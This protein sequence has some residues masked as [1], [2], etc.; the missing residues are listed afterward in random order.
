[1]AAIIGI[2]VAVALIAGTPVA[3][4]QP[5]NDECVDAET[6][7]LGVTAFGS[8]VDATGTDITS[9][10]TDDWNDVWYVCTAGADGAL[11]VDLSGSDFDTTLAVYDACGGNELACN[12]DYYGVQSWVTFSAVSGSSYYIRAAGYEGAAG[13]CHVL[14]DTMPHPAN[15]ECANAEVAVENGTV[16]ATNQGATGTDI[17]SCGT[18][19]W[20]DVWYVYTAAGT[21]TASLDVYSDFNMTLA[22]FDACS[23]TE[24][25][26]LQ[27]S[28]Y[29]VSSWPLPVVEGETYYARVAGE[30]SATGFFQA[31][32]SLALPPAN[33]ECTNAEGIVENVAVIGTNVDATGTDITSCGTDDWNDVWYVYTAAVTGTASLDVSSDFPM[34]LAFFDVC[35]GTEFVCLQTTGSASWPLPVTEGETY[36]AR[37]AGENGATGSFQVVISL[38]LPPANDECADAET[39]TE[40]TA[41]DGSTA[42]ATGTDTTSC[43]TDDWNDVWYVYTAPGAG[44]A[45][46]YVYS[47]FNMTLALF[48]GCSGTELA[49]LQNPAYNASSWP[50]AVVEGETYYIRIAGENGAAGSFEATISRALPPANDECANA[51]VVVENGTVY[52]TNQGATGTDITS[53]GTDDWNDVWYVYT[54][55]ATGTATLSVWSDFPMSLS[56]FDAC[57]GTES[58]C[59]QNGAYASSAWPLAVVEGETYYVR[60]AGD[61]GA[62][63]QGMLDIVVPPA[64]DECVNAEV[65]FEGVPISGTNV[66]ATGTDISSCAGND[67][68]DVWYVCTAGA[69][70]TLVVDLSGSDFDTTLAVYDACGGNELACNDNYTGSQSR[71]TLSAASGS[72]Y[73]IRVAG[74]NGSE[75]T[76]HVLVDTFT[77]P[78][79]D[80][81]ANAEAVTLGIT[82]IGSNYG[83]TGTDI[84]SCAWNDWNDVWYVYTAGAASDVVVDLTGSNFNTTLAVYDACGGNELACNDDY[85][86]SQSQVTLSA[87]SGS[88][89]YIRVAGYNGSEG[90][91]H[92]LVFTAPPPANDACF[93][94]EGM[95]ENVAVTGTNFGATGTDVS[96]CASNDWNDVWYVYT[97]ATTDTATVSIWS[98]FLLTFAIYDEC[99][100]TELACLQNGAYVGSSRPFGFVQGETYYVRIAGANGAVGSFRV[101]L[102]VIVPPDNDECANAAVLLNAGAA[103]GSNVGATGTDITS[104]GRNDW[105]DVWYAYTAPRTGTATLEV[106]IGSY[107]TVMTVAVFDACAGTELLSIDI[108]SSLSWPFPVTEGETY[109]IRIA[110]ENGATSSFQI[111]MGMPMPPAND[112][113]ADA[114]PVYLGTP[115]V[116][117]T[118]G[119]TGTDITSCGTNDSTDVWYVYT[120]TGTETV[121]CHGMG[122]EF[123]LSLAVFDACSGTELLCEEEPAY[124]EWWASLSVVESATYYIRLAGENGATGF[125]VFE[126]TFATPPTPPAND[127]CADAETLL[128]DVPFYG[129]TEGA[130]GT[131]ITSCGTNDVNDVWYDFTASSTGTVMLNV[132]SIFSPPPGVP[133][134]LAVFDGCSGT[135]ILCAEDHDYVACALNAVETQTYYLRIATSP[136][137]S[138]FFQVYVSA[139]ASPSNDEC[140]SASPVSLG[141]WFSGSNWGATGTDISSCGTND[142]NDV[143][144]E[145]VPEDTCTVMLFT[146]G[147]FPMALALFDACVGTELACH[148]NAGAS[149]RRLSCVE[150]QTYYIRIAGQNGRAGYFYGVLSLDETTSPPNDECADAEPLTANARAYG[151]TEGATGTA[152]TSCDEAVCCRDVWYVYTAI[153]TETVMVSL[154]IEVPATLAVL[155]ACDGTELTCGHADWGTLSWLPLSTVEG[156]DYYIRVASPFEVGG[157]FDIEVRRGPQNDECV[158]AEALSL[159]IPVSGSTSGAT[160]TDIT[161]CGSNDWNDVWY[162]FTRDCVARRHVVEVTPDFNATVALVSE[163]ESGEEYECGSVI[164]YQTLQIPFYTDRN[165]CHCRPFEGCWTHPFHVRVAGQEGAEGTF[166]ISVREVPPVNDDCGAAEELAPGTSL[167][168]NTYRATGTDISS[169]IPGIPGDARDVWYTYTASASGWVRVGGTGQHTLS[170]FEGCGG[171]ELACGT[172]V[173]GV[174]FDV[175]QGVAYAMRVADFPQ[176]S[177]QE[178]TLAMDWVTPPVNDTCDQALPLEAGVPLRGTHVGAGGIDMTSCGDT[179]DESDTSDVWYYHTASRTGTLTARST[180]TDWFS[181]T[182]AAFDACD[183]NEMACATGSFS[184]DS[185]ISFPVAMGSTY[186][187]RVAGSSAYHGDFQIVAGYGPD[188]ET[189]VEAVELALDE[190]VEGNVSVAEDSDVWYRFTAPESGEYCV[191]ATTD[192]GL[193]LDIFDACEGSQVATSYG[194]GARRLAVFEGVSGQTYYIR[195]TGTGGFRLWVSH[196]VPNHTCATAAPLVEG[197]IAPVHGGN[198]WYAYTA[199][200]TGKVTVSWDDSNDTTVIIYDTCG[201]TEMARWYHPALLDTT[202]G[203]TYYI[204]V[205]NGGMESTQVLITPGPDEDPQET[206]RLIRSIP[207]GQFAWQFEGLGVISLDDEGYVYVT[208][209]HYERTWIEPGEGEG[210][211][212]GHWNERLTRERVKKL[213]RD[214]ALVTQWTTR[215]ESPGVSQFSRSVGMAVDPASDRLFVAGQYVDTDPRN[216]VDVYS[217]SGT[218]LASWDLSDLTPQDVAVDRSGNVY[219]TGG[220]SIRVL[221]GETGTTVDEWT[222]NRW[223]IALAVDTQ[224]IVSLLVSDGQELVIERY[225]AAGH[226]QATWDAGVSY[227]WWAPPGRLAVDAAGNVYLI[228]ACTYEGVLVYAPDGSAA[229]LPGDWWSGSRDLA[230]SGDSSLYVVGAFP[231]LTAGYQGIVTFST[232]G[233]V[234][235]IWS[236]FFHEPSALAVDSGGTIYVGDNSAYSSTGRIRVV[237]ATGNLLRDIPEVAGSLYADGAGAIYSRGSERVRKLSPAGDLLL[238]WQVLQGY[239]RT[240]I[241]GEGTSRLWLLNGLL[242]NVSNLGEF[243][244]N[245]TQERV[246]YPLG[247]KDRYISDLYLDG[248]GN[249]YVTYDSNYSYCGIQCVSVDGITRSSWYGLGSRIAA[250]ASGNIYAVQGGDLVKM[251]PDG[252]IIAR[253][254][255]LTTPG[256][257]EVDAQGDLLVAY[258]SLG[259]VAEYRSV[260]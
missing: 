5:P 93:N 224:G 162:S 33:D 260:P 76:C 47:D 156:T 144:F 89:Y 153:E 182:L 108:P 228:G 92:V 31:T 256:E 136:G 185:L 19:D 107:G 225:D 15:D 209:G 122:N 12:D 169:C 65:V 95:V 207:G 111:T 54:A 14:V 84:S 177:G 189:C 22:L 174:V 67:W 213:T 202:E 78:A 128:L 172:V 253:T 8:N 193:R 80:A 239:G 20:N 170:V 214:G 7:S 113:C 21:G 94:A 119:A 210:E 166:Q 41:V 249:G 71:V 100:G 58:T 63:G 115:V 186:W 99:A 37:I 38:A 98:D 173:G 46:L 134:T 233:E 243:L 110:G 131:D 59:L 238:E 27:N 204:H 49:C 43:G 240:P 226:L 36:Y 221:D 259:M 117:F 149:S 196:E 146:G 28:A 55:S 88:S 74:Y 13:N 127:E 17:T 56:V 163:C 73:Y 129:T 72:S 75:G 167:T 152:I 24:L 118:T 82:A 39:L 219:I 1:M 44:I 211:G 114:E 215:E 60:I 246:I 179:W 103:T 57:S 30:S 164:A 29:N 68:R 97:A 121:A 16:Y 2:W 104:C 138:E 25:A 191:T 48:D 139:P 69:D 6:V 102:N 50:F 242:N 254:G 250:D 205:L 157:H 18:D 212:E 203:A 178:F 112:E 34:T 101:T 244:P 77:L 90:T 40:G 230:I 143:W 62:T 151:T 234:L 145:Y 192:L 42:N 245:G 45:F 160:G 171:P 231:D 194:I 258:P 79:N 132:G 251:T 200:H 96:S 140:A 23:G 116:G 52:A 241:C 165:S 197:V 155:D 206:L 11:T 176:D 159:D 201:G 229:W 81:C 180:V 9:C 150:G 188:N 199:G 125:L 237:D 216:Y 236:P 161:S 126:M 252:R 64:N 133:I 26:C 124:T 120:A 235:G 148:E 135:E 168:G 4:A 86:S 217:T 255:L 137:T 3:Y 223:P 247:S 190:I 85:T 35:S 123:P 106:S 87:A 109:Y 220:Q 257:F 32:I 61:N 208:D 227:S 91:C 66:H 198:E 222:T 195:A 10:G 187:L 147:E 184:A 141:E 158:N 70:G 232:A 183:G 142:W 53:C 248:S 175:Y 83:A 218:F 105:N 154:S 51:E 130:T 181:G